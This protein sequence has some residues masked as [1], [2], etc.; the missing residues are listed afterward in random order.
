MTAP[1]ADDARQREVTPAP[2][3]RADVARVQ[4]LTLPEAQSA[5]VGEIAE[6][7]AEPDLLQEFHLVASDDEIVGF[8]KIDRDFSRRVPRL[9]SR[10]HGLRGVLIGGQYQGRGFGGALFAVLPA[11]VKG[12]YSIGELWLSVDQT[13]THAIALYERHG[14]Q[15]DGEAHQGRCGPEQVMRLDLAGP[16]APLETPDSGLRA[17]L[18]SA[19]ETVRR[20]VP[21]G[22]RF[23]LGLLLVIGGGFGFLPILGFWM[24]PLGVAVMALDIRP[25]IAWF[26]R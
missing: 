4:H 19:L 5:F 18:R 12:R 3:A 8:F 22:L 2:L 20:R 6:M 17:W 23:L 1:R 7:T 10:A 24:I 14:W 26:R 25:L 13:N 11:Y 9:P 16:E 15:A 21:P